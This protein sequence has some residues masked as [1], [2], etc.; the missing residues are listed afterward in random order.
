[1]A[2]PAPHGAVCIQCR[3]NLRYQHHNINVGDEVVLATLSNHP[4]GTTVGVFKIEPNQ[5][6]LKLI[7]TLEKYGVERLN[8]TA[9]PQRVPRFRML[10]RGGARVGSNWAPDVSM[11]EFSP[12]SDT[13]HGFP[14][15]YGR[16]MGNYYELNIWCRQ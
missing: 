11:A 9:R 14:P 6:Y 1:M 16:G 15:N 3:V 7:G 13:L 4:A 5:H 2:A 8:E 12:G 10:Q